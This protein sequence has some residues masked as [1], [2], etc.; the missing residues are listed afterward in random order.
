VDENVNVAREMFEEDRYPER[1]PEFKRL[2]AYC[3]ANSLRMAFFDE[4]PF[5]GIVVHDVNGRPIRNYSEYTLYYHTM[6]K[7]VYF[8]DSEDW[9]EGMRMLVERI[10]RVEQKGDED[11]IES[12]GASI[13]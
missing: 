11:I 9:D 6:Y 10:D 2:M 1:F 13:L 8:L 7:K 12:L 5:I 4:P 3:D